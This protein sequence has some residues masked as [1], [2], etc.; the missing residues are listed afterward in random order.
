MAKE[1]KDSSYTQELQITE[2]QHIQPWLLQDMSQV[3]D[4]RIS[5]RRIDWSQLEI[6]GLL[7]N[8]R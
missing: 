3:L 7:V 5:I 2:L 4:W 6:V 1:T 8:V